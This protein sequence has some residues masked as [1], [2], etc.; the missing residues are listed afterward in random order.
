[1]HDMST[2]NIS[3]AQTR[4]ADLA[5]ALQHHAADRLDE[6]EPIYQR[7]YAADRRDSEVIYLLGLL[8]CDLGLF[9][10]ACKL[11]EEALAITT[12]FPEAR[13]QMALALNGLADQQAS[14]AK[15]WEA[16]GISEQAPDI[17]LLTHTYSYFGAECEQHWLLNNRKINHNTPFLETGFYLEEITLE[18][19]DALRCFLAPAIA[20]PFSEIDVLPGYLSSSLG[21]EM[22]KSL[23]RECIYYGR[24]PES[25]LRTMEAVIACMAPE[26]ESQMG[27]SWSVANVRAWSVRPGANVGPNAWHM[28][29]FSHYVRKLMFYLNTPCPENGTIEIATRNG[30]V[31]I[32]DAAK[33]ACVLLDSAVLAHRGRPAPDKERPMIELTLI[34]AMQTST[35]CIWAGQN[36]R[37][38]LRIDGAEHVER[39]L[40]RLRHAVPTAGPV[41]A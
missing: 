39:R 8:C 27:Q 33:P 2:I 16:Q 23:N 28:D 24:P 20:A 36:A 14:A 29:G 11:L 25:A 4:E 21:D 9:E 37:V 3:P 30:T 13:S 38:P 1:M 19:A 32:V 40:R 26:L 35:K 15:L 5:L 31:V 7:L 41:H 12:R 10:A 22:V 17:P 18:Q 34:P 6:A